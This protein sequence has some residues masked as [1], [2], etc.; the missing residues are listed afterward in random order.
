MEV[1]ANVLKTVRGTAVGF[2]LGSCVSA[3]SIGEK[4]SIL[5][6][7]STKFV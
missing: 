7:A 2:F 3:N 6:H 1:A 4:L 5:G